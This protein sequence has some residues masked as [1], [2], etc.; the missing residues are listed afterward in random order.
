[1]GEV[2]SSGLICDLSK[3]GLPAFSTKRTRS[4]TRE[5]LS[6]RGRCLFGD[7]SYRTL[8]SILAGGIVCLGLISAGQLFAGAGP[9]PDTSKAA[10]FEGSFDK[11]EVDTLGGWAWDGLQPNTPIKVEIYN[12]STLLAT[13]PAEGF[14]EDL[15][16]AG[17]GDGRHAFN[18]AVPATLRDGQ[19]HT[20]S[21]KYAGTRSDLPGSPKTQ[22][23]PKS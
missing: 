14:R 21:V 23:F 13:I 16:V 7:R 11:L 19:T 17:K 5:T 3:L 2:R 1:M 4:M 12:G 15:K 6:N 10:Q 18:Y 22:T 9:D 8:Y 20:I